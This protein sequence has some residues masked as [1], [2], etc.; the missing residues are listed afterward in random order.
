MEVVSVRCNKNIEYAM[1]HRNRIVS[2]AKDFFPE[3]EKFDAQYGG[4]KLYSKEDAECAVK[5]RFWFEQSG[6]T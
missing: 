1:H 5:Q 6:R 4:Q 3:L 2:D